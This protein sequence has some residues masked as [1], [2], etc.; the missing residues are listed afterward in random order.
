MIWTWNVLGLHN[1]VQAS[2]EPIMVRTMHE[3]TN[4]CHVYYVRISLVNG[5]AACSLNYT[6]ESMK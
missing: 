6:R 3:K 4:V 1:F 5:K 2:Y